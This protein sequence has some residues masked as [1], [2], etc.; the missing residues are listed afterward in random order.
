MVAV[1]AC[2]R[3]IVDLC[4]TLVAGV[5]AVTACIRAIVD[6]CLTLIAGVVAIAACIRAGGYGAFVALVASVIAVVFG[7]EVLFLSIYVGVGVA[8]AIAAENLI[9]GFAREAGEEVNAELLTKRR[10]EVK[11]YLSVS[12][13]LIANGGVGY[14]AFI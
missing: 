10:T 9:N 4:F 5:V 2:I 11:C 6:L 7:I 1:A 13:A 14:Y 8:F 12:K 3:A